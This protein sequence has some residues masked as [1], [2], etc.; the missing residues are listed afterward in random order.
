VPEGFTPKWP[1][2]DKDTVSDPGSPVVMT[3]LLTAYLI[4]VATPRSMGSPTCWKLKGF[5]TIS[6]FSLINSSMETPAMG[7]FSARSKWTVILK[8]SQS[9]NRAL[10]SMHH[11][12]VKSKGDGEPKKSQF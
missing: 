12:V 4:I 8:G 10:M 7:S 6:K 1:I 2:N 9:L 5:Y 3:R 11:S